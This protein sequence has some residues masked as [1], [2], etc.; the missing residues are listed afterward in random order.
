MARLLRSELG[1][2]LNAAWQ[3]DRDHSDDTQSLQGMGPTLRQTGKSLV[4]LHDDVQVKS[5]LWADSMVHGLKGA[6][7]NSNTTEKGGDAAR[8]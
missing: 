1:A 5:N 6:Q 2:A 3:G 8:R 4:R 7:R